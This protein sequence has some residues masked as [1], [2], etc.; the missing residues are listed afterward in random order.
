MDS[1]RKPERKAPGP[2]SEKVAVIRRVPPRSLIDGFEVT[3]ML[4][5][6][7]LGDGGLSVEKRTAVEWREQPF[8]WVDNN[9]VATIDSK[10]MMTD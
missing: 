4:G 5:M 1:Q 9:G 10:E 2:P 8:M 7:R 6:G 3:G